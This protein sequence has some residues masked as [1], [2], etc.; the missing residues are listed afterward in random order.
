MCAVAAAQRGQLA[1]RRTRSVKA[2]RAPSGRPCAPCTAAQVENFRTPNFPLVA[3]ILDWLVHRCVRRAAR[4][5]AAAGWSH[6]RRRAPL[7]DVPRR[8]DPMVTLSDNIETPEDR[9]DFLTSVVRIMATRARVQL[10]AK[11]LYAADGRAVKELHKV[12]KL[13]YDAVRTNQAALEGEAIVDEETDLTAQLAARLQEHG[14]IKELSRSITESGIRLFELLEREKDTRDRRTRV[15]DAL[16]MRRA[17]RPCLHVA[18]AT[19]SPALIPGPA[20]ARPWPL[21]HCKSWTPSPQTWAAAPSTTAWSAPSESRS[22]RSRRARTTSSAS[23]GS[24]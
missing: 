5:Q 6:L 16:C 18:R 23:T 19:V 21:R 7:A 20:T 11:S 1:G 24:S 15:C 2:N 3:D 13:L 22:A 9:V 17:C 10:K 8:Y 4:A 12:A 14:D